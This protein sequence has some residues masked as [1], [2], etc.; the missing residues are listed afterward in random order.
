MIFKVGPALLTDLLPIADGPWFVSS[1][2]SSGSTVFVG[3]LFLLSLIPSLRR[4]FQYH[5]AEHKAINAYEAGEELSP[6]RCSATR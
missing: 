5:A 1:R 2:G 4:V 3:Y 6:R